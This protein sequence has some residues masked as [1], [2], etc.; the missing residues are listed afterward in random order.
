MYAKYGDIADDCLGFDDVIYP[1]DYKAAGH[2]VDDE[3]HDIM[4]VELTRLK[5]HSSKLGGYR[6]KPLQPGVRLTAI[7]D[8]CHSGTALDLPFIY[9]TQVRLRLI[10]GTSHLDETSFGSLIGIGSIERT[11]SSQ[12]SSPRPL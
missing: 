7:F 6:V 2:I 5:K 10:L 3:M 1:V 12:R 9:S 8:S 4:Y 11:Q